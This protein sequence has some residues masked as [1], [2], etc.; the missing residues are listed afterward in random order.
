MNTTKLSVLAVLALA[1]AGCTTPA[2]AT[3]DATDSTP[4]A[5]TANGAGGTNLSGTDAAAALANATNVLPV[6]LQPD[7]T[8]DGAPPETEGT[9][10]PSVPVNS[11][12]STDADFPTWSGTLAADVALGADGIPYVFYF[13]TTSANVEANQLPPFK[14]APGFY[15]SLTIG[16]QTYEDQVDGPPTMHAGHVEQVESVFHPS[17]PIR[18]AAGDPVS[19]HV[20]VIY[21]HVAKA[22]EFQ[23]V[24]GPDHPSGFTLGAPSA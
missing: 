19:F 7:G 6:Y 24:M 22:A 8:L 13:T 3:S 21:T 12:Q 5:P 20:A 1:M 17:T 23:F 18:F 4:A 16:N 15:V 2:P 9:T 10:A 14:D 11:P